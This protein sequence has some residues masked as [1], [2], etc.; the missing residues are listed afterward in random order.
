MNKSLFITF[1]GIDGVG[2]STQLNLVYH[3]LID[4][5]YECLKT[6]EP[7]GTTLGHRIRQ[8]LLDPEIE[9]MAENTEALLYAADRAQHIQE[10]IKPALKEGKIVICDRFL[11]SSIAYQGYGL[12][13]DLSLI[14]SVNTWAVSGIMPDLTLCLDLEPEIALSRTEGDRIEQR[15]L[16]YY[17]RVRDGFQRIAQENPKRF[18]LIDA[19]GST[20]QVFHRVWDAIKRRGIG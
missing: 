4:L 6:H 19:E 16:D 14:Q 3:K 13:R 11:D 5:G 20:D 15:A 18:M 2:K 10:V 8:L 17:K 9:E 1:E 12:R 7:G